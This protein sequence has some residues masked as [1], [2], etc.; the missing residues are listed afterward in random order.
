LSNDERQITIIEWGK[1]S[2]NLNS[3]INE[4]DNTIGQMEIDVSMLR[5][6]LKKA[7]LIEDGLEN[8][9]KDGE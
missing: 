3:F 5:S 9:K 4:L 2:M 7:V 6:I 1:L 8:I